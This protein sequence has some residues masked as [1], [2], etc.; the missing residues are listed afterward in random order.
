MAIRGDGP[1]KIMRQAGHENME[2]TMAYGRE[3]ENLVTSVGEPFPE[4]PRELFV[5]LAESL[6]GPAAW[7]LLRGNTQKAIA[8]P[9]GFEPA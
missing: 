2:T 9:A 7:G 1:I 8:S 6:E 4:L 3:A 5:S